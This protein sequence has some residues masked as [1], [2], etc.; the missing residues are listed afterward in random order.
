MRFRVDSR[1]SINPGLRS[2]T[3][4]RYSPRS[5]PTS[6]PA[7]RNDGIGLSAS[8]ER[9]SAVGSDREQ[10]PVLIPK[11]HLPECV[12]GADVVRI[13]MLQHPGPRGHSKNLVREPQADEHGAY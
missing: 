3:Q 12:A 13:T 7:L 2:A 9:A 1:V 5:R 11:L 6:P 10:L 8:A 4:R